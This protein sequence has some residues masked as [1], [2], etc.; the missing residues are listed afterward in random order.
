MTSGVFTG[1]SQYGEGVRPYR[2]K[3]CPIR[4]FWT[5]VG[6]HQKIPTTLPTTQPLENYWHIESLL[7]AVQGVENDFVSFD[8]RMSHRPLPCQSEH[9]CTAAIAPVSALCQI[10]QMPWGPE[11]PV[12]CLQV[13]QELKRKP[14]R[15]PRAQNRQGEQERA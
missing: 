9:R 2:K 5:T 7:S 1:P 13:S 3:T 10:E 15:T 4:P 14:R 6:H 8:F 12:K 11:R